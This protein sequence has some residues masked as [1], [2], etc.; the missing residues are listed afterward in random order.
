MCDYFSIDGIITSEIFKRG[1]DGKGSWMG[2]FESQEHPCMFFVLNISFS[3]EPDLALRETV[4][5][6]RQ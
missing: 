3:A 1:L 6:V 4:W 2:K 5:E